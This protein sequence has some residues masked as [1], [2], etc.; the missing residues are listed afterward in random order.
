[1]PSVEPTARNPRQS[2]RC[3]NRPYA[4]GSHRQQHREGLAD[5]VV[6]PGA[7]DLFDEEVVGEPKNI[8]LLAADRAGAANGETR[9]RKRM[10]ADKGVGQVELAAERH[11]VSPTMRWGWGWGSCWRLM[12]VA[13]ISSKAAFMR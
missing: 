13:M 10:T 12:A 8:E 7:A 1:M 4:D 2:H 5:I 11:V 9:P 3:G 6:K